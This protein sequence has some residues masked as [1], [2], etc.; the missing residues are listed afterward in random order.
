MPQALAAARGGGA[1]EGGTPPAARPANRPQGCIGPPRWSLR[2]CPRRERAAIVLRPRQRDAAL[3][4]SDQMRL[5][6]G[7]ELPRRL[8][9]WRRRQWSAARPP[10]SRRGPGKPRRARLRRRL[11]PAHPADRAGRRGEAVAHPLLRPRMPWRPRLPR[12]DCSRPPTLLGALARARP[13]RAAG[14]PG[15]AARRRRAGRRGG[16]RPAAAAGRGGGALR[17]AAGTLAQRHRAL[18][19]H[20]R[21]LRGAAGRCGGGRARRR[22]HGW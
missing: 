19:R 2:G 1:A 22:W 4:L 15:M 9:A 11:R 17:A 21:R 10:C 14:A 5:E 13:P 12:P 6:P 20:P 7:A 8:A 16:A 3:G 18:R